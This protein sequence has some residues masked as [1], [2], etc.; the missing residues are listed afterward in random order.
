MTQEEALEKLE[1]ETGASQQEIKQQYQEFY[2]EFQIRITNAPT[3]HQKSLYQK[4]LKQLEEAFNVLTGQSTESID[5]EIPWTSPGETTLKQNIEHSIT[6]AEALKIL[7]LVEPYSLYELKISY[8]NKRNSYQQSY[9]A[10]PTESLKKTIKTEADYIKLAAEFLKPLAERS[11]EKI[12]VEQK[13]QSVPKTKESTIGVPNKNKTYNISKGINFEKIKNLRRMA[14]IFYILYVLSLIWVIFVED[15]YGHYNRFRDILFISILVHL[16]F[17]IGNVVSNYKLI[18][19]VVLNKSWV[20]IFLFLGI[21]LLPSEIF[22]IKLGVFSLFL[23]LGP[24]S[25]SVI[26]LHYK[27]NQIQVAQTNKGN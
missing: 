1:L 9:D 12:T 6:K 21:F 22:S 23:V 17:C 2:N 24:Y 27:L 10:A 5:S 25:L 18:T 20:G 11:R 13:P 15:V 7:E 14:L 16:I 26:Y 19:K 8:D 4:K 3:T